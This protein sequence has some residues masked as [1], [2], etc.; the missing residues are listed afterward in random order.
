MVILNPNCVP[1]LPVF[2]N[3]LR[4]RL[5]D[6]D[7]VYP[8]VFLISLALGVIR[9]LIVKNRPENRL[10]EMRIM[11]VKIGIADEN[12]QRTILLLQFLCN[13]GPGHRD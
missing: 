2:R 10:A 6:L 1:S 4:K 5:V 3:S 7:V 12:R 8:G 13:R 9:N 11:A